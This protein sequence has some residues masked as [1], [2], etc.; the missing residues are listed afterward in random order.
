MK[1][2]LYLE[3]TIVS[4]L[5]ARPSRDL[6]VAAHQQ[7]THEWWSDHRSDFSIYA[8]QLVVS[9][10]AGGDPEAAARRVRL[11]DG[12]DLLEITQDARNLAFR[13]I[14]QEAVPQKAAED[15]LHVAVATVNAIGYLLTWN[16][17]HIA[18]ARQQRLL[19][20]LAAEAG[21]TLPVICTPEEL[22]E[23]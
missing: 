13:F 19:Q 21:Y 7:V 15:A 17:K 20:R 9:E 5:A 6:I 1:S 11:L 3:T 18:N 23:G 2:R 8:S 16:C 4:Y 10:S 12:I 14:Q 22:M